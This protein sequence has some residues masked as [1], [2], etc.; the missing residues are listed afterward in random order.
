M[1]SYAHA[2]SLLFVSSPQAVKASRVISRRDG[3]RCPTDDIRAV[4]LDQRR[5][6]QM[7]RTVPS[8]T[9]NSAAT[10]RGAL[11]LSLSLKI[12]LTV[13]ALNRAMP[14]RSPRFCF[15]L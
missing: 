5:P 6:F 4:T 12:F 8:E 11:P 2:P 13:A 7:P 10:R 3:G 9:R 15:A 1:R 14:F